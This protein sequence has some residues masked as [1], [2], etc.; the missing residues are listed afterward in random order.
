MLF[1]K[2]RRA[3]EQQ[4]VCR[5][6]VVPHTGVTGNIVHDSNFENLHAHL[7]MHW[8]RFT[9]SKKKHGDLS[10]CNRGIRTSAGNQSAPYSRQSAGEERRIGFTATSFQAEPCASCSRSTASNASIV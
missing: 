3:R 10:P 6:A 4:R 9:G 2:P 8:L 5:A 1:C 7:R